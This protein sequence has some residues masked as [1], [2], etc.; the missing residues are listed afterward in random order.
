MGRWFGYRNGYVDLCRLYTSKKL[1]KWYRHVAVANEELRHELDDMADQDSSP[2][3]YG[4]KVRTH[5]DGMLITAMNKM[6]NSE[7]RKVT[8]AGKL[9]QI[10]RFYK[11]SNYNKSN[12]TYAS[13]WLEELGVP[14][15]PSK[16]SKNNYLWRN[17]SPDRIIEFL[18][19][20]NIHETCSNASPKIVSNYISTQTEEGE[21]VNWTVA[22]INVKSGKDYS[23]AGNQIGLTWR[24]DQDA[25]QIDEDTIYLINNNLITETDQASDLNEEEETR[26]LRETISNWKPNGRSSVP[27]K[28]PSPEWIRKCRKKENA[29]LMIYLFE[30]GKSDRSIVY[31]DIYLGYA[32]SFPDSPTAVPVEYKVDEVYLRNNFDEE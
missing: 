28:N 12:I 13:K 31:D 2:E 16:Q 20:I 10:T 30:S 15:M 24:T 25:D 17:V 29:L 1:L 3:K 19:N 8:Y 5:P 18:Q 26:A 11:S 4:L 7:T 9:V 27:P 14:E 32:I 21:L 23:I 6:R 22:L